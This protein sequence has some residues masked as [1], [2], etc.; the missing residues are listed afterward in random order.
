MA[1]GFTDQEYTE[2]IHLI[3]SIQL[4]LGSEEDRQQ[5]YEELARR[6]FQPGLKDSINSWRDPE[7]IIWDSFKYRDYKP[8]LLGPRT[9]QT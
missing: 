7:D 2:L 5:W 8:I 4:G 9:D 1:Y 3:S 6:I